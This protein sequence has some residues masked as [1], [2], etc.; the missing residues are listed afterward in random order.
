MS[1][2]CPSY[3]RTCHDN[4]QTLSTL[5]FTSIYIMTIQEAFHA[6]LNTCPAT[7]YELLSVGDNCI[8][9]NFRF[10]TEEPEYAE[11]YT[12]D[13]IDFLSDIADEQEKIMREEM[14]EPTME[15]PIGTHA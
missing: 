10:P 6:W 7:D 11:E 14:P 13:Q 8:T 9:Y 5:S 12:A 1:K 15:Y 2:P 4:V 3:V